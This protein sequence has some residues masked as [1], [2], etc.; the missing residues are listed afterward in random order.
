MIII[1]LSDRERIIYFRCFATN[2]ISIMDDF[3][4]R[5]NNE[6]NEADSRY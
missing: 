2:M 6:E 3:R 5:K 1:Y 4:K